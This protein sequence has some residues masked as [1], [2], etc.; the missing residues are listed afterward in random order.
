MDVLGEHVASV[1][2]GMNPSGV[3]RAMA[4]LGRATVQ[5]A[6]YIVE[7]LEEPVQTSAD[8]RSRW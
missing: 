2:L 1:M 7:H 3:R 6:G 4:D 8:S 5:N